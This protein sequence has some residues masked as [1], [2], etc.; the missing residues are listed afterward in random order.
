M[1]TRD[2]GDMVGHDGHRALGSLGPRSVPMSPGASG[3]PSD[4]AGGGTRRRDA[5]GGWLHGY[6]CHLQDRCPLTTSPHGVPSCCHGV[7][8]CPIMVSRCPQVLRQ[9]RLL[10][11]PNA[12]CQ[13]LHLEVAI[14]GPIL[15]HG[16]APP[17]GPA[18]FSSRG[19]CPQPCFAYPNPQQMR[20][21]RTTRTTRRRSL[22]RGRSLR[23]GQC[24]WKG[25]GQQMTPP[26]SAPCPYGMPVS[27][28]AAAHITLPTRWPSWSASGE[29]R[30]FLSLGAGLPADGRGLL[31]RGV[32]C[33][34][35]SPGVAL[36]GMAVVEI[37]LLSG[38]SPHRADL[39]KVGAQGDLWDMLGG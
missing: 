19:A 31:L 12:T 27:G 33:C 39:D 36:T 38:F 11:P 28:N 6:W 17:K 3:Q 15:Y 18:P 26:P 25:R 8:C 23:K 2:V 30:N 21:T 24:P 29:G 10:S 13:A 35:R 4:S 20:T 5:D 37:T 22:R 16:E 14:T 1:R 9:F 34:R 32:A 7:P